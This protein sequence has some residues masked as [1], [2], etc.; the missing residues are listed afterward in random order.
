MAIKIYSGKVDFRRID[1]GVLAVTSEIQDALRASVM[2]GKPRLLDASYIKEHFDGDA[3]KMKS[4]IRAI[5]SSNKIR[6]SL[7]PD[8][9][10]TGVVVLAVLRDDNTSPDWLTG[11]KP[12]KPPAPP[13]R[14]GRKRKTGDAAASATTA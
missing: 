13:S 8:S 5:A 12:A 6:A 9:S 3:S 11:K 4:R 2:D 14:A 10:G 1:S 7:G